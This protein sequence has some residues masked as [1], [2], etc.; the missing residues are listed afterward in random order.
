MKLYQVFYKDTEENEVHIQLSEDSWMIMQ[1]QDNEY[2]P[3]VDAGTTLR[4]FEKY[5]TDDEFKSAIDLLTEV[6]LER[7]PEVW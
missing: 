4:L 1:R 5:N 2:K 6:A 3:S 7:E